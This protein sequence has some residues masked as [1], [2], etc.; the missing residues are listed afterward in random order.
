MHFWQV[1]LRK[2]RIAWR[3]ERLPS[4]VYVSNGLI[5]ST[6]LQN[7]AGSWIETWPIFSSTFILGLCLED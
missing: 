7:S 6:N 5:H 2:D 4:A 1:R 3:K